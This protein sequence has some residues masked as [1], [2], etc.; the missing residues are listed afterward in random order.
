[1]G[2]TAFVPNNSFSKNQAVGISPCS[3]S[4]EQVPKEVKRLGSGGYVLQSTKLYQSRPSAKPVYITRVRFP[5][6]QYETFLTKDLK[7]SGQRR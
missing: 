6:K 4:Q 7:P 3:F 2:N 5:N 1:M